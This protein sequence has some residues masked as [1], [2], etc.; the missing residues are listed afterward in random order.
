MHA[1]T[2]NEQIADPLDF[3]DNIALALL[4]DR[5]E[6]LQEE[7]CYEAVLAKLLTAA[8]ADNKDQASKLLAELDDWRDDFDRKIDVARS[9]MRRLAGAAIVGTR[10]YQQRVVEISLALLAARGNGSLCIRMKRSSPLP[11]SHH[12]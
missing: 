6:A 1:G 8:D 7:R 12:A 11:L 5:I 2:I 4:E 10:A 3:D 9:E